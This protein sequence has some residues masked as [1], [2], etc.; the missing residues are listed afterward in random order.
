MQGIFFIS[1]QAKSGT[2]FLILR[3]PLEA[4]PSQRPPQA[5]V[6]NYTCIDSSSHE[7]F[8]LIVSQDRGSTLDKNVLWR[9]VQ[10]IRSVG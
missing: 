6:L 5:D 7:S 3:H 9:D 1:R 4:S 8:L 10:Q 2:I